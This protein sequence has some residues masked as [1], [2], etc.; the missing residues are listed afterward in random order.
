LAIADL[1][2]HN[3]GIDMSKPHLQLIHSSNGIR[4]EA[5]HA[6]NGHSFRPLVIP[7]GA[8][9]R[10]MPGENAWE[11]GLELINLGLLNYLCFLQASMTV[12]AAHNWTDPD[13]TG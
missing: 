7:G 10:S 6:R 1:F 8:R 3:L 12:L 2:D 9:A 4:P 13:Q 5:K 11:A